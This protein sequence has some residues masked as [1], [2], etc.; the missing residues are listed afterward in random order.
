MADAAG[1]LAAHQY[2]EHSYEPLAR[3]AA[4][5][6]RANA[7][8]QQVKE[9]AKAIRLKV[10]DN[11]K[12]RAEWLKDWQT[13]SDRTYREYAE[14]IIEGYSRENDGLNDALVLLE[15]EQET[16]DIQADPDLM[17]A[18][19]SSEAD[20]AAGRVIPW[21]DVK[22]EL[23]LDTEPPVVASTDAAS[24]P[25]RVG[26]GSKDGKSNFYIVH[27]YDDEV[28]ISRSDHAIDALRIADA[29]NMR[30]Y[31]AAKI[32][33]L[34]GLLSEVLAWNDGNWPVGTEPPDIVA[35]L[36]RIRAALK[37]KAGV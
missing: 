9:A 12:W 36:E 25:Y 22:K 20:I 7:A 4:L 23:G 10:A 17:A 19:E 32:E 2:G 6:E 28:E 18:I 15:S 5:G 13:N 35:T 16:A 31:M 1:V 27:R 24:G 29:L 26:I 30:N 21:E 37:E 8:E 3:L 11:D 33:T 14:R 34:S